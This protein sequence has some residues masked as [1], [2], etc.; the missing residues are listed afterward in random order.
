MII[1]AS[2]SKPFT[3]TA[4]NTARRGAVINDYEQEIES[5]YRVVEDS[6]QTDISPPEPDE[7]GEWSLEDSR[8]FVRKIVHSI[9]KN[10]ST[11]K[12]EDDF[13]THGCD[14]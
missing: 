14:R 6:I 9:M 2:R 4:K 11:M 7:H 8:R 5:L 10:A 12:D 1:L 13:F 3:Y